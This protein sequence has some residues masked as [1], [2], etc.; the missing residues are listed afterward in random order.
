[1]NDQL[2]ESLR[3]LVN[4]YGLKQVCQTLDEI[5]ASTRTGKRRSAP[6][7]LGAEGSA[8][9]R[10]RVKP[11]ASRHVAKLDLP[12]EKHA[13]ISELAR[14]FDE[15]SF[16]PSSGDIAHFCASYGINQPSSRSRS[17]AIPRVFRAISEME[18]KEL[19]RIIDNGLYSGPSRLGPIANAIRKR[20]RVEASGHYDDRTD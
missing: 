10:I 16:L 8:A 15:K 18:A 11:S 7:A 13:P 12:V 20:S 17:S 9:T 14:R 5:R 4:Q 19:K 2:A 1:M 3:S 6:Q